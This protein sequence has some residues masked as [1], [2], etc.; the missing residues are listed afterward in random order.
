MSE[1]LPPITFDPTDDEV[2]AALLAHMKAFAAEPDPQRRTA[3]FT[4]FGEKLADH[5]IDVRN[6]ARAIEKHRDGLLKLF[7]MMKQQ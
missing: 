2:K 3:A 4:A 7:H 1:T 6:K 5:F